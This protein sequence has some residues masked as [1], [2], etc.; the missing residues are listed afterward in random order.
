M[1]A[2]AQVKSHPIHP[3]LIAFP[4]AFLIAA[5]VCNAVGWAIESQTWW[6]VGAWLALAGI[7]SAL[8]AAVPGIID[9]LYAIPP[10]SSANRR[11]TLH[12]LV[13]TAAVILFVVAWVLRGSAEAPPTLLT[14]LLELV[15][16]VFLSSG[17]WLGGT[18][19]YR[20]LIAV[21]H[22]YAGAGKWNEA[23]I[24]LPAGRESVP[25][26]DADE[27]EVDQMKLLRV[28]GRRIVLARS[29]QGYTAFEDHCSHRGGSLA[30]GVM[31]CGTVQCLWHGSQFDA[32]T[33]QPKRGPAKEPIRTFP[34]GERDGK[35]HLMPENL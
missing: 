25:V 35:I 22:R 13:N 24:E 5:F 7:I 2:V 34:V 18:L 29:D 28:N 16:L 21:D 14:L 32:H 12:M 4:I 11:A 31:I 8:V 19:V 27:L 9:Y 20:N 6:T 30:G 3:M 10:G 15:A 26:A 1:R 23:T 17:G 33:G